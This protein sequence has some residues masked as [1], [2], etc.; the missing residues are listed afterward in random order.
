[1]K[2]NLIFV[3][4]LLL[5]TAAACGGTQPADDAA[6][7]GDA[8]NTAVAETLVASLSDSAPASAD[9]AA[10]VEQALSADEPADEAVAESA[11]EAVIAPT[12]TPVVSAFEAD[13]Q[14]AADAD[15][16]DASSSARSS[17][18]RDTLNV[19]GDVAA[20]AD[21]SG[22]DADEKPCYSVTLAAETIP[23]GTVFHP[24]DGFA[25][26]WTLKNTGTCEWGTDMRFVWVGGNSKF[27]ASGDSQ[28]TNHQI[29]PGETVTVTLEMGAPVEP[30]LYIG[31]Y[32][33]I[34]E[35]S[36]KVITPYGVWLSVWVDYE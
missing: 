23:D 34:I 10:E 18:D 11:A 31:L 29:L 30:G 14:T 19:S 35:G 4:L 2:K 25:K 27:R 5:L 16:S 6:A 13:A 28:L 3:L 8:V 32:K 17:S 24:G 20:S 33:I 21:S 22:D 7:F 1:M 12:L 36:G 26:S 15:A 9:I